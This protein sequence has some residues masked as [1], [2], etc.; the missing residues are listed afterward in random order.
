MCPGARGGIRGGG[1]ICLVLEDGG[2]MGG[3]VCVMV[4]GLVLRL[5]SLGT[6]MGTEVLDSPGLGDGGLTTTLRPS[7]RLG[8]GGREGVVTGSVVGST[9]DEGG[10]NACVTAS[11]GTEEG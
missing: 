10:A 4:I 1:E 7:L 8:M 2:G 5:S 6:L 3:G 11:I 9:R